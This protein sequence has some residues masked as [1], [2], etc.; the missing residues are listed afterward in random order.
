MGCQVRG[1]SIRKSSVY[2]TTFCSLDLVSLYTLSQIH[3]FTMP[4][5]AKIDMSRYLP[6][7]VKLATSSVIS[8]PDK[9]AVQANVNL[10]KICLVLKLRRHCTE[11]GRAISP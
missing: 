8:I 11:T 9:T 10:T 6:R 4:R 2:C 7:Y 3:F 1:A 5:L